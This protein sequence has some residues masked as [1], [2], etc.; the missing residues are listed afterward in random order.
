MK[1]SIIFLL[2]FAMLFG[3]CGCSND[4]D[5]KG[6]YKEE[7]ISDDTLKENDLEEEFS[8]GE[9]SNNVYESDFIGIGFKLDENW[10]FY[11]EEEIMELNNS[12]TDMAGEEYEELIK[13]ATIVYD[14]YA[15]DSDQLNNININLEKISNT[16]LLSLDI[17]ENFESSAPMIV[18]IFK[19]MGC[20]NTNWEITDIVIDGKKLD[21]LYVTAELNDVPMYQLMFQKKCNGYL[22]CVTI[23]TL[24]S[25]TISDLADNFYWIK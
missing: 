8:L 23:S 6:K 16:K 10:R 3:I 22:A 11:S 14:M 19:N 20:E 7:N 21:A 4:G 15:T 2:M 9:I 17:V 24:F 5:I 12:A 25:D 1:K 18:D 13:N